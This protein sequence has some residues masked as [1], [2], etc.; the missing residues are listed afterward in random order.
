MVQNAL[1]KIV[2]IVFSALL[3]S[4]SG[5]QKL[6]KSTDTQKKFDK[7]VE[8]FNKENYTKASELFEN[9]LPFVR[10]TDM[11]EDANYF[12][13][14]SH[15]KSG[16]YILGGYYYGN[17]MTQ[18]PNSPRI[19]DATYK[20]AYCY[21]LDSPRYSLDQANTYKAIETFQRFA[22][23]YPN[24]PRKAE[25]NTYID[26]LREKLERKSFENAKL[27][28][29]V[30]EYQAAVIT[31][32]N[33][34]KDFPDT[35]Y[36]EEVLFLIF[37]SNYLFAKKSIIT[38]QAERFESVVKSYDKF[39]ENYPESKYKKEAVRLYES[40]QQAMADLKNLNL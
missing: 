21:Y 33:T 11:A 8:Y 4:C 35:K 18:F 25:C 7:A 16:D 15:Y 28:Y 19:E 3:V 17:F 1:N 37:K 20:N 30:S 32:N 34:L 38:K 40:A 12:L 24:S 36:R 14:E 5:Y 9:L 31:L 39:I 27:Y 29:N 10:G 22:N 23:K 13:A 26:L 2:I 6:L